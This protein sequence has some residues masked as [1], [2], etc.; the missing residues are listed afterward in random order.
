MEDGTPVL[1]NLELKGR[2]LILSVTSAERAERGV[3]LITQ[4]LG[5]MVGTP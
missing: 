2:A 5:A 3:A 4:A 1:G